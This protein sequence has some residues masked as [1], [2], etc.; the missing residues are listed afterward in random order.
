M[1]DNIHSFDSLPEQ[2]AYID[3]CFL[4]NILVKEAKFH[5]PC[6]EYKDRLKK[7]HTLLFLSNLG[8]DEIW[9]VL[10]KL[11]A[12]KDHGLKGWQK[13]IN[14]HPEAVIKYSSLLDQIT[15]AILEIPNLHIIEISA[16]QT[17]EALNFIQRYGLLPR[18]AIHL[19]ATIFSDIKNIITT[20]EAFNMIT[21]VNVYTCNL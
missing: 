20:D 7:N 17:L 14:Q 15:S 2:A 1:A 4:L 19:A 16:Q 11:Q 13:Y 6:V 9:Y 8:L 12:I 3:P 10:I 18:D 5:H 21:N